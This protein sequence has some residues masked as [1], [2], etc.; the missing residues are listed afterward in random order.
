MASQEE[1]ALRALA[2]KMILEGRA[3]EAL[4][5]LSRHYRVQTPRLR[6]G[7]PKRCRKAYGCYVAREKTIYLRSSE[8]YTNPFV[9]MHEFYHH[10]RWRLGSHR[11]TEKHADRY[12]RESILYYRLLYGGAG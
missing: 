2:V 11:G 8:E 9:V 1:M 3:E 6:V 12:A 4:E 7:L 10:I 5:R